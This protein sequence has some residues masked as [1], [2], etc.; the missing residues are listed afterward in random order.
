MEYIY[1]Q[2]GANQLLIINNNYCWRAWKLKI[3]SIDNFLD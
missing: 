1:G 3:N 2:L